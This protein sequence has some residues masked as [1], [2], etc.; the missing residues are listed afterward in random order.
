VQ[1]LRPPNIGLAPNRTRKA[2]DVDLHQLFS[3]AIYDHLVGGGV[4]H[5]HRHVTVAFV[6]FSGSDPLVQREGAVLSRAV[7]Q[8]VDA[9]Q[10]AAEAHGVTILSTDICENGGKIILVSGAP[11]TA[12]D[13]D[14]RVL[15]AVRRIV[16]PG[17]TLKVRAGVARGRVFAG[18]YGP[19][20]RRVY[21]LTGDIV[22][23]AARLMAKA[24]DGEIIAMP[25]V[26]SRS[27]TH[28]VTTRLEPFTVKGKAAPIEALLVGPVRQDGEVLG[29]NKL[30]LIGRD[31]EFAAFLAADRQA[32]AGAGQVIDLVGDPGMGK[33]R[34]LEELAGYSDSWMLWADGDIYG[35]TTPYQPMQRMLRR[36]LGL[37]DNADTET[38]ADV[39]TALVKQTAPDLL[40]WLPL[41]AVVAG[42]DVEPTP[43]V[44][45]LDPEVRKQRLE[46][47]TSEILGR[48]LRRPMIMVFNDVHFMDDATRDLIRRLAADVADR[49]WL[50]VITRRP[51]FPSILDDDQ[52]VT[53]IEL[54]PL[55]GAAAAQLL[56]AATD[57]AP[58]PAY[59]L[60][61]LAERAGGNP[62]FLREV[63]A[64]V[65]AGSDPDSLPDSVEGVIASRLDRLPPASRSWLRAAA[66]LG[67]VVDPAILRAVLDDP[68]V[69]GQHAVWSELEEFIAPGTDG[70]LHF[71]HDLIRL[72]AYEGLPYRRRT[73][74]HARAA[75][76]LEAVSSAPIEQKA[77]LLSLHC[78]LGERYDAAWQY[79]RVA[80]DRARQQY[81][82]AE[83]AECYRRALSAAAH[84]PAL[85]PTEVI[86]V[87]ETLAAVYMDLGEMDAAE[88]ALRQARRKARSDP[89]R[90]AQLYVHTMRHRHH[91][92]RHRDALEWAA[93]GRRLLDSVGADDRG[94]ARLRAELAERAAQIR[95]DQG[96]YRS[97]REWADRAVAEAR[98]AGDKL[99]EARTLAFVIMQSAIRGQAVDDAEVLQAFELCRASGDLRSLV[100]MTNLVGMSAYFAG[101]WEEAVEHYATAEKIAV[102]IGLDYDAAALAGNRA[103]VLLQQGRYEDAGDALAS[104]SPKLKATKATSFLAFNLALQGR[105]SL[106]RGDH[107][108]ALAQFKEAHDLCI[109]MGES[110]EELSIDAY[111]AR[112]HLR[113]GRLDE[114]LSLIDAGISRAHRARSEAAALPPLHRVRGEVL[115]AR[116]DLDRAR[117]EFRRALAIARERETS[118]EIEA[119]LRMLERFDCATDAAEAADW[120]QERTALSAALGIV[121]D[122][123]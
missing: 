8:V 10:A 96:A 65:L 107:E 53:T 93:K 59:R 72:T 89:H 78:L 81:G 69:Q 79:S 23:L 90:L 52:P 44:N 27:R 97:A 116:G 76:A 99:L 12:G 3:P 94:T 56:A 101:R 50:L 73:M 106:A 11:R 123:A 38:L 19:A 82:V 74:L 13:D 71:T 43:E 57:A 100:R 117:T 87:Y 18:D 114:A 2:L 75:D 29:A 80:G 54:Q 24:G 39:L 105:V 108:R 111:I 1:L 64:G 95:Y 104:A 118:Y 55:A 102:Q 46:Q 91:V 41:I 36:T 40:P 113:A 110:Y 31:E 14:T 30:P 15:G 5:E 6:E 58:L 16:Q 77:P 70:M 28:F 115:V 49:P 25:E 34:L 48:I 17:M 83:A 109:A 42:A 47:V 84:L 62:L 22:N 35:T 122:P 7:S 85:L 119:S 33:S 92:G 21:S 67:M 63:S 4:D 120:R 37:P 112:C 86:D 121:A 45:L 98:I 26:V 20:Y 88:E 61:Q 68:S 32:A 60:Q 51:S 103:E 9:A 66:V